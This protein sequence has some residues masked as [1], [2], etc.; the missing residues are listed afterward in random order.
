MSWLDPKSDVPMI[1][2]YV[3]RLETFTD[4][5]ADGVI[6]KHELEAQE[7]RVVDLMKQ[8]EPRLDDKLHE[9]VTRLLCELSA[10][11]IMMTLHSLAQG[12]LQQAIK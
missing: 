12:R 7:K 1:G 11:N 8:I 2:D 10:Y 4:A 3:Q 6:E 5:L 9:Q